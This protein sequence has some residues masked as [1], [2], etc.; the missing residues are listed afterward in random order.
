[1]GSDIKRGVHSDVI[2]EL[3]NNIIEEGDPAMRNAHL[4]F[5]LLWLSQALANLADAY[6]IMA[7]VTLLYKATG[8]AAYASTMPLLRVTS[9]MIS[10]LLAPWLLD[11]FSLKSI[12][13]ASQTGQ[14][15]LLAALTFYAPLL[16][17]GGFAI[18]FALV[19]AISFLDGWTV[20]ARNALVPRLVKRDRLVRA[21]SLISTT[22]Q[23]VLL[24]GWSTG[25]ILVAWLGAEATLWINLTLFALSSVAIWFLRDPFQGEKPTG[26]ATGTVSRRGRMSE[27]WAMIW[28]H[29]L[30]RRVTLMDL[31]EM[32]AGVIWIAA[33]SMVFVT[34][35]LHQSTEWF[36]YINA[37]YYLGTLLGGILILRL[38]DRVQQRLI[39]AM[40]TG[41]VINCLLTLLFTSIPFAPFALFLSVL[42]GPFYQ[43]RDIA[44][45]S[46]LQET[47]DNRSLPKV[48]AAHGTLMYGAF[49]LSVSIAGILADAFGVRTVYYGATVLLGISTWI[50]WSLRRSREPHCTMKQEI[51]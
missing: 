5:R 43:L 10:G 23:I 26:A 38:S 19:F 51:S 28:N 17:E 35:V 1:M 33:I 50:G 24:A 11:R 16:W 21:N 7:L 4:S 40:I 36:G 6:Y 9:Q 39:P 47:V 49:G 18:G 22:D 42:M 12:L 2:Q 27:G 30:L 45:R 41:S 14:T 46:L 20:P 31:T 8:S 37:G 15:L 34:E 29:P 48:F 3:T 32:F 44:Q 13:V 25:G